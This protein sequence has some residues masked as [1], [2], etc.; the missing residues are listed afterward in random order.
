MTTAKKPSLAD[1]A[2]AKAPPPCRVCVLPER[3]EIDE[4]YRN[5]IPRRIIHEWLIDV[6]GYKPIGLVDGVSA[7]AID[8]HLK[9]RHHLK[10][11]S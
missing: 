1:F 6:R 10:D 5:G 7:T 3:P 8:N 11:V 2:A 9:K 4:A